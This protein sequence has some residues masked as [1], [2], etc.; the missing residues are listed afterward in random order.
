M[1]ASCARLAGCS[2]TA[3]QSL[4]GTQP[5]AGSSAG[6][7]RDVDGAPARVFIAREVEHG[8]GAE[9]VVVDAATTAHNRLG[10]FIEY[11]RE[12]HAR[13]KAQS[14]LGEEVLPVVAN[15]GRNGEALVD[16]PLVLNEGAHLL[17]VIDEVDIAGVLRESGGA[18][19]GVVV[20]R[21]LRRRCRRR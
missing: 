19:V 18:V 6:I 11:L 17:L 1:G 21:G 12:G 14:L 15:A 4:T 8:A 9:A 16:L 5:V 13:R 10:I 2:V 7:E 20:E 3:V